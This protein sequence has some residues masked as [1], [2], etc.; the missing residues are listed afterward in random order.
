MTVAEH[1]P[2]LLNRRINGLAAS[3]LYDIIS[4]EYG[5]RRRGGRA[6]LA[7]TTVCHSR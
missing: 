1:T 4:G 6:T 2:R 5:S 7:L 3:N